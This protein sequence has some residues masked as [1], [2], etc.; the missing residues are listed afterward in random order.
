M[1]LRRDAD[2]DFELRSTSPSSLHHLVAEGETPHHY[3]GWPSRSAGCRRHK[4]THH[5]RSGQI[6][7]IPVHRTHMDCHLVA[8]RPNRSERAVRPPRHPGPPRSPTNPLITPQGVN[9]YEQ[10]QTTKSQRDSTKTKSKRNALPTKV[11]G[12]AR[13]LCTTISWPFC[14]FDLPEKT[15]LTGEPECVSTRT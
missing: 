14:W 9:G 12:L 10:R 13:K 8:S 11:V 2:S 15:R 6:E 3:A 5:W 7:A 4:M 1:L